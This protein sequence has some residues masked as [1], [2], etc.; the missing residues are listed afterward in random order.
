MASAKCGGTT[1]DYDEKQCAPTLARACRTRPVSGASVAP[2][3]GARTSQQA[4][5]VA[6]PVSEPSV[7]IAGSLAVAAQQLG[8]VW[9]R[10]VVVPERL[11]G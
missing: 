8:K 3:L 6:S 7:V 2:D 4:G 11:R 1:I 10:R 5:Q 9:G